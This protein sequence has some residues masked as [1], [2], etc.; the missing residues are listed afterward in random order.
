MIEIEI[1]KHP[2][3]GDIMCALGNK[4]CG[5]LDEEVEARCSFEPFP[6]H[7]T[8]KLDSNLNPVPGYI[9]TDFEDNIHAC[10]D[11]PLRIDLVHPDKTIK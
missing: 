2:V 11:Y 10:I 3:I 7:G 8:E 1:L 9:W 6:K 5:F 4:T